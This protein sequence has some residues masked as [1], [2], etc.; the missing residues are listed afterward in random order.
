MIKQKKNS[1]SNSNS[2]WVEKGGEGGKKV[3]KMKVYSFLFFFS[4]T[5][6]LQ[7]SNPEEWM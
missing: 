4:V 1:N 6:V 2:N 3:M 7:L 5:S